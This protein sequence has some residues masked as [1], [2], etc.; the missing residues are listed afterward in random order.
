MPSLGTLDLDER[1][2]VERNQIQ[3]DY[4]LS[5]PPSSAHTGAAQRGEAE[6]DDH[7]KKGDPHRELGASAYQYL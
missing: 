1:L 3:E 5:P 7:Q 2:A 6:P 4:L